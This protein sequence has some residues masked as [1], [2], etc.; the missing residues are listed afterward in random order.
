MNLKKFRT[1]L[2][3]SPVKKMSHLEHLED[4]IFNEGVDDLRQAI[5][6]LQYSKKILTGYSNTKHI[7]QTKT[8]GSPSLVA[9]LDPTTSKFFVATKG[10]FA[11]TPKV[12]YTETDIESMYES[13]DLQHKL[14][15]AL[16]YLPQV[17]KTGVYQGDLFF[18][19]DSISEQT[20]LNNQ[21][22]AFRANTITYAIPINTELAKRIQNAKI[23]IIFHAKYHGDKLEN[24]EADFDIT[25]KDFP[26]VKDVWC[27][28]STITDVSGNVYFTK[29]E[30]NIFDMIL[31]EV[32]KLFNT[33]DKEFLS[34]LSNGKLSI[35][36]KTYNNSKI[37]QGEEFDNI[38][39]VIKGLITFVHAKYDK[40]IA[41]L[42]TDISKEGRNIVRNEIV[43]FV[44]N[45]ITKLTN[46]YTI[47]NLLVEAKLMIISKLEELGELNTFV[48]TENG[49]KV[50]GQEGYVIVDK[51]YMNVVKLVDRTEFSKNNFNMSK[52]WK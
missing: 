16:K 28:S 40:E 51:L 18:V 9:G 32:G 5:N 35:I 49:F 14:K 38:P 1:F 31:T 36:I 26:I 46:V 11:K 22:I 21:Y 30:T 29:I 10:A 50:V 3:E 8:D 39:S 6:F 12:A 7:L 2:I 42:K 34:K 19:Y 43:E 52:N 4:Y 13:A 27:P 41:N 45:N 15:V 33:L 48:E 25:S 23:G 37:R 44:D 47:F 20:I 24:L 17:I